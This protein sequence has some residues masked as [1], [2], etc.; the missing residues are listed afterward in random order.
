MLAFLLQIRGSVGRMYEE[1]EKDA[2][3]VG[4]EY[5]FI[6]HSKDEEG[7]YSNTGMA[8]EVSD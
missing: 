4:A 1:L 5:V 6:Y 3:M 8:E 2:T 7:G